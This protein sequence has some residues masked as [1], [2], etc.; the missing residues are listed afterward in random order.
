MYS[1]AVYFTRGLDNCVE[2]IQKCLGHWAAFIKMTEVHAAAQTFRV[3]ISGFSLSDAY[4]FWW[5]MRWEYYLVAGLWISTQSLVNKIILSII[6]WYTFPNVESIKG[7]SSMLMSLPPSP[8][9]SFLLQMQDIFHNG[10][11]KLNI[12]QHLNFP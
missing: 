12:E 6:Q 1:S 11:F 9:P 3:S 4:N 7:H 8:P 5:Q 10:L 2:C